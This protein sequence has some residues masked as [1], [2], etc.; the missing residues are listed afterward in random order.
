MPLAGADGSHKHSVRG[1]VLQA[2][3]N[4]WPRPAVRGAPEGQ[5]AAHK[6]EVSVRTH[7]M[8]GT[9]TQGASAARRARSAVVA[10]RAAVTI[11]RA[12]RAAN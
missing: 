8:A 10:A 2:A 4:T 9:A 3:T 5:A 11:D 12:P 7:W 6:V 1:R